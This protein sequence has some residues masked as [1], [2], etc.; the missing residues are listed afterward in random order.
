MCTQGGS[1]GRGGGHG[2]VGRSPYVSL[3]CVAEEIVMAG[4]CI[5]GDAVPVE[6]FL[7]EHGAPDDIVAG[8]AAEGTAGGRQPAQ[9][10][11]REE[12][13]DAEQKVVLLCQQALRREHIFRESVR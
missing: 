4:L 8:D 10:P 2:T 3:L 7:E 9:V 5:V 6:N 12:G 1:Q 11:R 13:H